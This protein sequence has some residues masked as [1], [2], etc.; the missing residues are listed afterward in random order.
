VNDDRDLQRAVTQVA[1]T[2]LDEYR[3]ALAGSGA[4]REHG[5]VDRLTRDVDLFTNVWDADAFRNAVNHVTTTL[6]GNGYTVDRVRETDM[7]ATLHVADATGTVV[8]VDLSY[9]WRSQEPTRLQVGPVLAMDDA[10]AAKAGAI[11]SREEARDLIDFDAIRS[12]GRYTDGQLVELM[13]ER[14]EGFDRNT[15]ANQ[16]EIVSHRPDSRFIEYGLTAEQIVGLRERTKDFAE[17]LRQPPTTTSSAQ[18]Q[19]RQMSREQRLEGLRTAGYLGTPHQPDVGP[20][21]QAGAKATPE[22]QAAVELSLRS[23]RSRDQDLGL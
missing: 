11:Y 13:A 14:D 19:V 3:F 7:F 20:I 21:S 17:H 1:L 8:D 10:V 23:A 16:L 5:I 2:G 4:I 22:Q 9:D 12:S 6:T 15:Y 18:D